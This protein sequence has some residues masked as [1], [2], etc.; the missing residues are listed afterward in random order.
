MPTRSRESSVGTMPWDQ[1]KSETLR[2]IC[3]DLGLPATRRDEMCEL[4][5]EVNSSG[6]QSALATVE[7]RKRKVQEAGSDESSNSRGKRPR[8]TSTTREVGNKR[9]LRSA[10]PDRPT[11]RRASGT[12][13]RKLMDGVVLSTTRRAKSTK[14]AR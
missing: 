1:L 6:L 8:T 2:L 5:V 13:K 10:L 12:N 4:L 14:R 11:T 3:K 9:S 7:E